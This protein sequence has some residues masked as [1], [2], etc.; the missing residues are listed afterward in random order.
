[1]GRA[2]MGWVSA[3]SACGNDGD[4]GRRGGLCLMS[5][6]GL[7]VGA[8]RVTKTTPH[9]GRGSKKNLISSHTTIPTAPGLSPPLPH[10]PD[11]EE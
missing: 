4:G 2:G 9:I 6:T 7:K 11:S 8:D 5:Q 1:M 10:F 3:C